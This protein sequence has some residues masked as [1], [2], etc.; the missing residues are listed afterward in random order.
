MAESVQLPSPPFITVAGINNFRDAGGYEVTSSDLPAT[1]AAADGDGRKRRIRVVRRG[2][3][4]RSAEPSKVTDEAAVQLDQQL[5]IKIVYDLRSATEISKGFDGVNGWKVK[6]IEG[7]GRMFVPV[8]LNEDYS[9]AALAKRFRYYTM[10]SDE[11]FTEAYKQIL[12]AATDPTNEYKPYKTILNNLASSTGE[13]VPCLVHCTAG[14]D[15]TGVIVALVLSL[16]GVPDEAVAHEYN[17]TELGLRDAIGDIAAYLMRSLNI[18]EAAARRMGG[19]RKAS[20]LNTLAHLREK[21]GSIEQCVIDL[22]LLTSE[23]IA[24]LRKNLV[25]E[26]DEGDA[27]AW[28]ENAKLILDE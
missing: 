28:E 10:E 21:H 24:Q 17:L 1:A 15:R 12:D 4:Y 16:C 19:A 11:G 25:V 22:G 3:L 26:A 5:G 18:D 2:I 8:F 13:A 20:M 23:G 27:V 7:T 9:P 14:K 6:E